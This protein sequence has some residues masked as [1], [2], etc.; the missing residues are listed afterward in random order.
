MTGWSEDEKF[1]L[2]ME[3][4]LCAPSRLALAAPDVAAIL[5]AV[6]PGPAS[7][8]LDLGCGP[9]A[10]AIAFSGLGHRVSGV[11]ASPRLLQRARFSAQVAGLEIEWIEADMRTFHRPSTFDLV[12]SLYASFGYFDDLENRRVLENVFASLA[13]NGTLVLDV[14]GREAAARHWQERRWHEVNGVLY[15]ERC[16]AADDW[17]SMESQWIVVREGVREDF[18]VKQ[19]LYA[20]AELRELLLSVGFTEIRLASGLD[21]RAPYDESARRLVAFAGKP[22]TG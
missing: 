5:T 2:A 17:T 22:M 19:R 21:G 18:R 11:D 10:H 12:C 20:G 1:W 9:G 3:P 13:P 8:V 4:A 16:S 7:R 14:V 6:R 15:L